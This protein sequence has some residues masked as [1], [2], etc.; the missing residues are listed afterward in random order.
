MRS[1]SSDVN[2]ASSTNT[3]SFGRMVRC[4]NWKR[5]LRRRLLGLFTALF[6]FLRFCKVDKAHSE[7]A[8]FN[9]SGERQAGQYAAAACGRGEGGATARLTWYVS[10]MYFSARHTVGTLQRMPCFD[11]SSLTISPCVSIGLLST[12][13]IKQ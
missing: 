6:I 11:H 2:P 13:H 8:G 3:A 4:C 1:V 5:R 7:R 9:S 10:R 12:M